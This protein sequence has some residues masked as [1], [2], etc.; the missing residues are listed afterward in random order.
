MGLA[1]IDQNSRQAIS[2]LG[3]MCEAPAA[4][5][6]AIHLIAKHENDLTTALIENVMAGG[7]SAGRGLI[8]GLV[9]GAHL[10]IGAIPPEWLSEMQPYQQIVDMLARIDQGSRF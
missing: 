8:V 3:Q 1:S 7:D 10:G 2:E 4:F 9:L 5:P 6:A